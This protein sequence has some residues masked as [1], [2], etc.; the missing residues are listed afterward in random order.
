MIVTPGPYAPTVTQHVAGEPTED[1]HHNEVP[2]FTDRAVVAVAEWSPSSTET[3]NAGGDEVVADLILVVTEST[4]ASEYDEW[5]ATDGLRYRVN[6]QPKRFHNPFDNTAV[7]QINLRR[8][9]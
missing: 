7:T 9:T 4:A 5:T 8:I 6:G 1:S 2:A 3:D